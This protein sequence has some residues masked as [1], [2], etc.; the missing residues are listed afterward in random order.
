MH[1]I[2]K[3]SFLS[4]ISANPKNALSQ[5]YSLVLVSIDMK[6]FPSNVSPEMMLELSV[7]ISASLEITMFDFFLLVLFGFV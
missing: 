7:I 4:E 5:L 2:N 3:A 1:L 6:H